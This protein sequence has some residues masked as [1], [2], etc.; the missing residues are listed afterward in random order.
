MNKALASTYMDPTEVLRKYWGHDAFRPL[1]ED[2]VRSAMSGRDTLALLPTGGGKSI[3]FQVP[4]MAMPGV[5]IVISP[6]I[7]LMQDQVLNL[8]KRGIAAVAVHAGM[9]QNAIDNALEAAAT[10]QVKFLYLS[11]ERLQTDMVRMRLQRMQINLFAVDEAHCISQWGYDFRPPYLLIAEVRS[12]IPTVPVLALT[13]TATPQVV[14]D[15]TLRLAFKDGAVFRKSFARPELAY[16]VLREEDT[17]GRMLRILSRVPGSAIVYVRNRRR[18]KEVADHLLSM[19]ISST[20][21]HAGLSHDER[22]KRQHDWVNDRTRVVVATNAFGMGIDKPDVRCVI[23]IGFPDTL[24]AYFQEAGRG[25]R[26]GK[27]AYA[28]AMIDGTTA[29]AI[30]E[31]LA[32]SFPDKTLIVN[33]YRAICSQLRVAEGAGSEEW[34]DLQTEALTER[35]G[36]TAAQVHSALGFLQR[37]G[38]IYIT[39]PERAQSTVHISVSPETLYQEEVRDERVRRVLQTLLRSY[40]ALF[41]DEVAVDLHRISK[42]SGLTVDEVARTL[43]ALHG[44]KLLQWR[45]AT[46]LPRI[47]LVNGA[48]AANNVRISREG[49]EMRKEIR[50]RQM[51]AVVH[52]LENTTLC[53]S[54]L[55]LSYFGELSARTCGQCDVCLSLSNESVSPEETKAISAQILESVSRAA[56]STQDL[57][58]KLSR[59]SEKK[60]LRVLQRLMDDGL[61]CVDGFGNL[62]MKKTD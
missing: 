29:V 38:Y 55:L 5:C 61:I 4:A 60:V 36:L 58:K 50:L 23:H 9:R 52:F 35:T 31:S 19:G 57:P 47:N 32:A 34:F 6:L 49:Y 25:A 33:V 53:R 8:T 39:E 40:G 7:A 20:Y 48:L 43:Q 11:P 15:I 14:T 45:P 10:N 37:E 27:K 59:W 46:G 22:T 28:V 26:D 56:L 1:Q 42:R 54:V 16:M 24:E 2:I 62:V 17:K 30:R 51:N 3:C 12:Q 18:T 21:Y 44:R 13:A 41:E